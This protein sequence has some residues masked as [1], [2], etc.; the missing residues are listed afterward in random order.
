[1]PTAA[2]ARGEETG[3][4][5]PRSVRGGRRLKAPGQTAVATRWRRLRRIELFTEAAIRL[6]V[7][8]AR[9]AVT[10]VIAQPHALERRIGERRDATRQRGALGGDVGQ[11][12]WT[13][14]RAPRLAFGR[15]FEQ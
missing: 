10:Q 14:A 15:S 8:H 3:M 12:K 13:T 11:A 1:M 7:P 4:R 2:P 9:H 6:A 5:A